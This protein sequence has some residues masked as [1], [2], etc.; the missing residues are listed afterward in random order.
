MLEVLAQLLD[1]YPRNHVKSSELHL[2][3][4]AV[5]P[6]KDSAAAQ[7]I[8]QS[9]PSVDFSG[10]LW[11]NSPEAASSYIIRRL[12]TGSRTIANYNPLSEMTVSNFSAALAEIEYKRSRY[13][14]FHFEVY[15]P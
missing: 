12:E 8:M 4:I 9:L 15:S 10:I 7:E 6:R 5:L 2:A 1:H 14:L 13:P 3:L 11:S